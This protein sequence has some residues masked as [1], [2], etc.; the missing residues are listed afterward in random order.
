MEGMENIMDEAESNMFEPCRTFYHT[1]SCSGSL[2]AVRPYRTLTYSVH[3]LAT[4]MILFVPLLKP[5]LCIDD[6][7]ETG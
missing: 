5:L 6:I 4:A 1:F 3:Y 2:L 7:L